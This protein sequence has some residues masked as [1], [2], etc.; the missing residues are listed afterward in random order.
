MMYGLCHPKVNIFN[1]DA[2]G[3]LLENNVISHPGYFRNQIPSTS[4]KDT[5]GQYPFEEKYCYE[6]C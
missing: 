5:L 1:R 2:S 3:A 6:S 4:F